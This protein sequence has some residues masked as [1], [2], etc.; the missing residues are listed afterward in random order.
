M[1]PEA[2]AGEL[3]LFPLR[4]VLFPDGLLELKI[5]E[6]RYLDLMSRCMRQSEPFGVVCLK[7]GREVKGAEGVELCAVGTTAEL[8]E[9]DSAAA[10]ILLVRCRGGHRFTLGATRQQ[11]DGLWLGAATAIDADPVVAPSVAHADIVKGLAE[12]IAA[13]AAQ[14]AQPFFEPHHLDDAGWVA[15]RWCEILPLPVEA[16]QRLLTLADPLARLEVVDSLMRVRHD[17]H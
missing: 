16:R 8:V 12:A 9:V 15:N 14:G 17:A 11:G 1:S 2:G 13:L 10:G 7:G 6:A 4:A 5:F 3:P